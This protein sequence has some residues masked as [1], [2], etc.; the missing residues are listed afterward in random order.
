MT[1]PGQGELFPPTPEELEASNEDLRR[2]AQVL[3][4]EIRVRA[5]ADGI[6]DQAL[7]RLEAVAREVLAGAGAAAKELAP[8]VLPALAVLAR[9]ALEDA[10]ARRR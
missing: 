1:E 4:A 6:L 9:G 10:L 7:E 3:V 8:V 2:R 5:A